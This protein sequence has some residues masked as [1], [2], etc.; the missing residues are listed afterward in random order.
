MLTKEDHI[1]Y[2]GR[3][4]LYLIGFA[5]FDTTCCGNG[6]CNY[7]FVP[8]FIVNWKGRQNEEGLFVSRIEAVCNEFDKEE[9]RR[10]IHAH[11]LVSQINFH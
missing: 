8:G 7:A 9:I 3:K 11:E 4:V 10:L 1:E 5:E 2:N 6:G